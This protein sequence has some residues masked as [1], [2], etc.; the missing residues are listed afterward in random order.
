EVG[1]EVQQPQDDITEQPL[2]DDYYLRLTRDGDTFTGAYSTD[3]ENWTDMPSAVTNGELDGAG[4]GLF[5]L[6]ASQT[7]PTTVSFDYFRVEGDDEPEPEPI[8]VP[9]EQVSIQM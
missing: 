1:G 2:A 7:E 4:P 9:A 5:A 3:G 8:H 6:G